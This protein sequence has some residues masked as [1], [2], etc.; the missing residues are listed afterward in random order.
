MNRSD[1]NK[2]TKQNSSP[3]KPAKKVTK[4]SS[5]DK[6]EAKKRRKIAEKEYNKEVNVPPGSKPQKKV[7]L[8]IPE[9]ESELSD[10]AAGPSKQ[11]TK[12]LSES[13]LS[14]LIDEEPKRK[15]KKRI[16]KP[17]DSKKRTKKTTKSSD[18]DPD[19]EEIKRLQGW[20]VKCGIRKVW[21]KELGPYQTSKEKIRHLKG[22]LSDAGM[23]GRYSIEKASQ[24]REK[25]ELEADLEAV[26]E[27]DRL[28]G[29]KDDDDE[30]EEEEE[31]TT[32]SHRQRNNRGLPNFDFI[33][34][35]SE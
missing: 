28:W 26:K 22:M 21:G 1:S 35:D 23:T 6:P 27:G 8:S 4:R 31:E 16:D 18:L 25:R 7:R 32:A 3:V 10:A 17:K 11:A 34:Y 30:E 5:A 14:E 13:E 24:V 15:P 29:T 12:D 33:E 9:P 20:L 2:S 19:A